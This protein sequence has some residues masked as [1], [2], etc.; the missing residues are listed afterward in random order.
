VQIDGVIFDLELFDPRRCGQNYYFKIDI[1]L[2]NWRSKIVLPFLE[3]AEKV[4]DLLATLVRSYK[5]MVDLEAHVRMEVDDGSGDEY[6]H[7]DRRR[8]LRGSPAE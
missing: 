2:T 4:A 1:G 8:R 3:N 6:E 5:L 7:A